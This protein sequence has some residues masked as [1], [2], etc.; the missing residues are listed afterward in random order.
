MPLEANS[1]FHKYY[2]NKSNPLSTDGDGSKSLIDHA[3]ESNKNAQACSDSMQSDYRFEF[4]R[5][6]S[7]KVFEIDLTSARPGVNDEQD[8][9]MHHG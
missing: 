7:G 8:D 2:E 5:L 6:G 4:Q 1:L 3:L 9:V